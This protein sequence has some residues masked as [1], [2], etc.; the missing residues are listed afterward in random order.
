M[1]VPFRPLTITSR[2]AYRLADGSHQF[3]CI[4]S[5]QNIS[6]D[7]RL[8]HVGHVF[9]IGVYGNRQDLYAGHLVE[10]A[11]GRGGTTPIYSD[12]L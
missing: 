6:H 9:L 7:T 3:L 5:F 4:A 1:R 10:S 12:L 11:A 8:H 2:N